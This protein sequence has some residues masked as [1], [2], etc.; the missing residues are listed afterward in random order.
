MMAVFFDAPLPDYGSK[1]AQAWQNTLIKDDTGK[2]IQVRGNGR[3]TPFWTVTLGYDRSVS[4]PTSAFE[5]S[6]FL[7][8]IRALRGGSVQC[9]FYTPSPWDWWD[10]APAGVGDGT[11]LLFPF[12]CDFLVDLLTPVVKL[13]GVARPQYDVGVTDPIWTVETLD[14]D[15]YNRWAVTFAAAYVPAAGVVVTVSFM[16]RRLLLGNLIQDPGAIS[17]VDYAE[18]QFS[19]LLQGEEAAP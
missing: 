18:L 13:D 5:M 4:E 12:G 19:L 7:S 3:T 17:P 1:A 9:Y 16:G 11:N 14:D 15:A 6:V 8:A 2:V 10:D